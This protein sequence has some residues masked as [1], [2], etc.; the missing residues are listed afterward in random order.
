MGKLKV[1]FILVVVVG[2]ISYLT[3]NQ[4]VSEENDAVISKTPI[5]TPTDNKIDY[6]KVKSGEV[7]YLGQ[8]YKYSF[9]AVEDASKL[10]LIAN[11]EEKKRAIDLM[12]EYS[13]VSGING[14]FYDENSN[15]LGLVVTE[16]NVYSKYRKNS[17]HN[18]IVGTTS[19]GQYIGSDFEQNFIEAVQTGPLLF[20]DGKISNFSLVRDKRARRSVALNT[21]NKLFMFSIYGND[22]FRDGPLLEELPN[23]VEI[24]GKNEKI[25]IR[26]AINMDGGTAS[27]IHYTKETIDEWQPVGS[28]WCLKQ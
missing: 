27:A 17:L 11:Y 15:P 16:G 14:G 7:N 19:L 20:I 1:I 18:G 28:W 23:I 8:I 26:S 21:S 3:N 10:S 2:L 12:E 22:S 4:T 13:C 24:I 9:W 25:Q 6:E 5:N